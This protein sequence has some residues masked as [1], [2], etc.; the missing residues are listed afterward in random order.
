M[1]KQ[2]KTSLII[3]VIGVI[4]VSIIGYYMFV[5]TSEKSE[6]GLQK[7]DSSTEQNTMTNESNKNATYMGTIIAGDKSPYIDFNEVDFNKAKQEGKIIVLD[8]YANWCPICRAEQP[9][10]QAGF[11]QL[12]NPNVIGFRVNYND[13]ETDEIE[14]ALA[15]EHAITY[16]H[17]KVIIKNGTVVLKDGL[18]WNT[19]EFI[20]NVS[21][22]L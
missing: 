16:Q 15:K 8:Y 1:E 10:L 2:H 14:K 13:T 21:S 9:D 6:T 7:N 4:I 17:T 18:V 11:E 5:S 20:S 12:N 19:E 22:L 3:S